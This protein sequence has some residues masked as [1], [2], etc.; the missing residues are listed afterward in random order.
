MECREDNLIKQFTTGQFVSLD[1][2]FAVLGRMM[3]IA[4]TEETFC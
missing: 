3:S 4:N 2:R 1:K